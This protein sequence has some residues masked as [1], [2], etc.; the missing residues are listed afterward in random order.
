MLS[1]ELGLALRQAG[2]PLQ[3]D[4]QTRTQSGTDYNLIADSPYG[5][6]NQVVVM[7]GHLDSIFGA[8]ML[9]NASGSS[10]LLEIALKLART[11]TRN[12]LRYV[13]FGGEEVGLLGSRYYTRHLSAAER[14]RIA[15]DYDADVTAT[16]NHV[17]LIADPAKAPDASQFPPNVA[18]DSQVGNQYLRDYFKSIGTPVRSASF[19]NDGTDSHSF[20]LIGIP[21]TGILTQQNCC[22]NPG[23]VKLW[24]G[25]TGNYEGK[26]PSR[27]GG[28]VDTPGRWCDDIANNDP[29][30]LVV[31]SRA[32]AYAALKLATHP[33]AARTP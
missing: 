12:Q 27:N 13:W 5:D 3:L 33:F 26:I 16:P 8:G 29:A 25:Q 22:K 9:D 6:A 19:G 28:C 2:Q 24:G 23:Q 30:V 15:F 14:A 7:E 10:T 4:V 21:N 31:A 11:P 17:Y 1:H 18:P 32:S 20:S